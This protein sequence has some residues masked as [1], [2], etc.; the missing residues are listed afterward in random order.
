MTTS[1]HCLCVVAERRGR[2]VGYAAA[3]T[4]GRRFYREFLLRKGLLCGLL[5]LPHLLRL[6]NLR[7]VWTALTYFPGA[8]HQDPEAE[9]VSLVVD[10]EAQSSGLGRELWEGV[11]AGLRARGVAEMKIATD[12][13]N[14]R[15]NRMYLNRGCRLI[16]KEPLY[17]DNEV[18]VY[19]YRTAQDPY[20][21]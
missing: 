4:S 13:G 11:V 18:C 8:A 3:L 15:A 21:D 10:R 12:T 20:A 6:S 7:T 9:M 16:R 5:A 17:R 14:E 19:V 2:V 1:R